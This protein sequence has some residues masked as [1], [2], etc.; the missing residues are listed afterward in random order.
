[1]PQIPNHTT[2]LDSKVQT[3][4]VKDKEISL[5]EDLLVKMMSQQ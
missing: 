4:Q 3:V 1:M 5:Q 2:I